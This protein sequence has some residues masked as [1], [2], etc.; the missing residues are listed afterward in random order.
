MSYSP[1]SHLR[2]RTEFS[3]PPHLTQ[4]HT[5]PPV[6]QSNEARHAHQIVVCTMYNPL[7][8]LILHEF[9]VSS[10][11][12]MSMMGGSSLVA[13]TLKELFKL[14]SVGVLAKYL[15]KTFIY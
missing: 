6:K 2:G 1:F 9:G 7:I 15:Y 10:R 14:L 13:E 3:S 4:C 12:M 11:H 8:N 5:G